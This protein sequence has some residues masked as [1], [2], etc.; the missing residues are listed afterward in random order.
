MTDYVQI[1]EMV[2]RGCL[3]HSSASSVPITLWVDTGHIQQLSIDVGTFIY[4]RLSARH[5][6]RYVLGHDV[7]ATLLWNE[8]SV[9]VLI[10]S[11]GFIPGVRPSHSAEDLNLHLL[12]CKQGCLLLGHICLIQ[13]PRSSSW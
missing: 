6:D 11:R 12:H 5:V 8:M 7:A 10:H 2:K 3:P 4:R 1:T 13:C 9:K